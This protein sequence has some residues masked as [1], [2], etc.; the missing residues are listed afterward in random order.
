MT[1]HAWKVVIYFNGI[2]NRDFYYKTVSAFYNLKL[3]K[4]M[5]KITPLKMSSASMY[6]SK[7]NLKCRVCIF[8]HD[9]W[10]DIINLKMIMLI[11][12]NF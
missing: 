12:Y 2:Y 4:F 1:I 8:S 6:T 11:F 3:T 10:V 7:K 9:D 5:F